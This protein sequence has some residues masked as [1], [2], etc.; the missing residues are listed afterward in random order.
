MGSTTRSF[1]KPRV[2]KFV[3]P[4]V[5]FMSLFLIKYGPAVLVDSIN[6]TQEGLFLMI[7]FAALDTLFNKDFGYCRT[8]TDNCCFDPVNLQV[9]SV[10]G[11]CGI[12]KFGQV[13]S[14]AKLHSAGKK[15][16]DPMKEIRN[17]KQFFVSSLA[18]LSEQFV[19]PAYQTALV[20]LCGTYNSAIF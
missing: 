7:L 9:T 5:I 4:L 11:S 17:P 3:S 19:S 10:V 12:R 15:A 2:Y 8:E 13:G 1:A 14:F 16:D 18:G 6:S 20:Q